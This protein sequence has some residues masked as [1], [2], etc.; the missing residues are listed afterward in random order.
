MEKITKRKVIIQTN[1]LSAG[2]ERVELPEQDVCGVGGTMDHWLELCLSQHDLLSLQEAIQ[3]LPVVELLVKFE[4][5]VKLVHL[6]L[7]WVVAA[8]DFGVDP[9]VGKI[10]LRV[11]DLVGQV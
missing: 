6:D 9:A 8:E 11:R 3:V 10:A 4:A 1:L 7:L 2:E 5:V